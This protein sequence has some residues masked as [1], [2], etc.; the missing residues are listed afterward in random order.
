M[1]D[2]FHEQEGSQAQ[3]DSKRLLTGLRILASLLNWLAGL[4]RLTEEER[5]DAGIYL[6]RLGGE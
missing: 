3:Q 2:S 1:D 6:D 5:E 4:F